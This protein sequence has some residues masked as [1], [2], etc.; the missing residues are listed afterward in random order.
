MYYQ[1]T[2]H[3]EV[4]ADIEKTWAFFSSAENLPKITPPWLRFT[5]AMPG[6]TLITQD[7]VLDYK[8]YWL[9]LPMR[10][11]ARIIDWSPP[12]QFIDLQV[13]GPYA[14]WHHQHTFT[15]SEHGGTVCFDRVIHQLPLPL[16]RRIV[17][18]LIVRKQLL[19]VF[20]FRRQVIGENLGWVRSLQDDVR[21][22][23][24]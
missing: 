16:V 12:R 19:N 6:S 11:R 10:W 15:P 9:G 24:L 2:D 23:A 20:R 17:H 8:I 13:R 7:A 1:L 4:A 18:P 5:L 3:F 21:I 22:V 14:L